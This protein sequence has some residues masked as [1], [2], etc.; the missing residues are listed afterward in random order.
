MRDD[1]SEQLVLRDVVDADLDVFFEQQSDTHANRMAAFVSKNPGDR[2]AFDAHWAKIRGD[3]TVTIRCVVAGDHVAGYVSSF[4]RFGDREVSY[5]LGRDY[6]GRGIATEALL[7]FLEVVETRPLHARVAH[8]NLGSL[9]VL[10]KC[11]FQVGGHDRFFAEARGE[12]IDEVL[13]RLDR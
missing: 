5:W 8:D 10:Q 11:G 3:A 12:E 1:S 4:L 9:R 6:W 7:A 13:L 2:A